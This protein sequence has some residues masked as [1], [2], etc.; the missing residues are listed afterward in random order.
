M[1]HDHLTRQDLL[2]PDLGSEILL[3][4]TGCVLFLPLLVLVVAALAA[5]LR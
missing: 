4:A 3:T 2:K 1:K 5:A